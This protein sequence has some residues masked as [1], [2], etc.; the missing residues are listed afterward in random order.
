[1]YSFFKLLMFIISY[2]DEHRVLV[3]RLLA[4]TKTLETLRGQRLIKE[5]QLRKRTEHLKSRVAVVAA[6]FPAQHAIEERIL[7][8]LNYM[9]RCMRTI[10]RGL[11]FDSFDSQYEHFTCLEAVQG[12]RT[13]NFYNSTSH[14]GHTQ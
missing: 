5:Q 6:K 7:R 13:T 12:D 4:G 1:M 8:K 3:D 11:R 9:R 10:G 2:S 14:P